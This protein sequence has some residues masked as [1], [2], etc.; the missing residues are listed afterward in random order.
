MLLNVYQAQDGKIR[1]KNGGK[2]AELSLKQLEALGLNLDA[3][4]GGFSS[5]NY[6][7]AYYPAPPQLKVLTDSGLYGAY[8]FDGDLCFFLVLTVS[9]VT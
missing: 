8:V 3:L 7:A 6:Q 2:S 4:E 9:V 5:A 1:V